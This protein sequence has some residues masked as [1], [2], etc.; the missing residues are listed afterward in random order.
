[1]PRRKEI[2]SCRLCAVAIC[3]DWQSVGLLR[4]EMSL[5]DLKGALGSSVWFGKMMYATDAKWASGLQ[6]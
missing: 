1:L 3:V 2:K 4:L 6:K 5:A